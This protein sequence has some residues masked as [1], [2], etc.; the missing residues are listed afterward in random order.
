MLTWRICNTTPTAVS[1]VLNYEIQSVCSNTR[2]ALTMGEHTDTAMA[3]FAFNIL[4]MQVDFDASASSGQVFDWNF[5]DGNTSTGV[6]VSHTYMVSGT[7]QV[8]LIVT[9][10]ICGTIDSISQSVFI[11]FGLMEDHLTQSFQLYPNP[12]QGT[13]ELT[14]EL[15]TTAEVSLEFF[16]IVGNRIQTR[17]L[18]TQT[19]V[20]NE[21]VDL[22]HL[23]KGVYLVKVHVDDLALTRRIILQ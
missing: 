4:N 11:N 17:T 10:T 19:G 9:D 1:H 15:L 7:Y 23:P 22:S 14:F 12:S 18:G 3:S 21:R 13:F 16:D 20:V 2:I 8:T 5:G 6:Q